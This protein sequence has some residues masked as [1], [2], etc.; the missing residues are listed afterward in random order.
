MARWRKTPA[1][2]IAGRALMILWM[3]L[4]SISTALRQGVHAIRASSRRLAEELDPRPLDAEDEDLELRCFKGRF[5]DPFKVVPRRHG[6][7]APGSPARGLRFRLTARR[8]AYRARVD[9]SR[10]RSRQAAI[11]D[12]RKANERAESRA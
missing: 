4:V 6:G 12:S 8:L 3:G 5:H 11:A 2:S 9:I 7:V 1:P 10:I